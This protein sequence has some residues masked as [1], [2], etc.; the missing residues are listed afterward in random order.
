M[1]KK[2]DKWQ[3]CYNKNLMKLRKI[4]KKGTKVLNNHL[5][6]NS[7]CFKSFS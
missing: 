4:M 7:K 1:L 2:L 6:K 5:M 3:I